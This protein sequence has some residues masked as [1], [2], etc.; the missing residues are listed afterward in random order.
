MATVLIPRA[1]IPSA[2]EYFRGAVDIFVEVDG[3]KRK[4]RIFR[5]AGRLAAEEGG[6]PLLDDELLS[7]VASI[8]EHPSPFV[9]RFDEKYLPLPR[10]VLITSMRHHQRYF[11]I[12]RAGGACF[13]AS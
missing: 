11:P 10:D 4:D 2:R 9:G 3:A 8:T 12:A 6:T 5:E 1:Y 7:E 13:P